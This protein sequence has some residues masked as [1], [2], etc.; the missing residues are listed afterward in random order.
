MPSDDLARF[1]SEAV[2]VA[3]LQHPNIVQIYEVGED[4][5]QPFFSLEYV[6]GGSLAKK[7]NGTPQPPAEAA[8]LVTRAGRAAWSMPTS[9]ASSIAI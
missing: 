6:A 7:I 4:D 1:R 5:G 9:A 3:E 8:R 2:A